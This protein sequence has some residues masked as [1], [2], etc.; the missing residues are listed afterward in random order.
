MVPIAAA[1]LTEDQHQRVRADADA[2]GMTISDW[3]RFR[4]LDEAPK[5]SVPPYEVDERTGC[6]NWRGKLDKDGYPSKRQHRRFYESKHGPI[7]E[8]LTI[9]HRCENRRCVNPDHLEPL[10]LTENCRRGKQTK[11]TV[12]Q[13]ARIKADPRHPRDIAPDYGVHKA[14]IYDIKKGRWWREVEPARASPPLP[15]AVQISYQAGVPVATAWR[16][17]R[18][19]EASDDPLATLRELSGGRVA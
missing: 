11:L 3:L 1:K 7:P 8:G 19:A 14:T 10:T 2:A 16:W 4:L 5:P 12:E 17:L 13:V 18:R 6:W 9:D 15:S